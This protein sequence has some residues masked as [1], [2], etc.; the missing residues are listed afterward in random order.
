MKKLYLAACLSLG[1]ARLASGQADYYL[2]EG[3]VN[4]LTNIDAYNFTNK[5]LFEMPV[6]GNLTNIFIP[7]FDY[8]LNSPTTSAFDFSD[9]TN[10][11]NHGTMTSDLG[12]IFDTE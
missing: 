12:Y 1:L 9:V 10:F 8:V 5:G 6:N 4:T 2:N 3:I 7:P 11:V